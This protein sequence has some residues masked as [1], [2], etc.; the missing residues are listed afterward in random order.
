MRIVEVVAKTAAMWA[1]DNPKKAP[2]LNSENENNRNAA[3]AFVRPLKRE[4]RRSHSS[5]G[6]NQFER[7][8][9]ELA[10]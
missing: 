6:K 8:A 4:K 9:C 5:I 10:S 1:S 3:F 2:Q 7:M